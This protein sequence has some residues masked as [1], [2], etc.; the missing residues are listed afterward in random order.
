MTQLVLEL[1]LSSSKLLGWLRI[2]RPHLLHLRPSEYEKP[3]TEK[4]LHFA[5]DLGLHHVAQGLLDLGWDPNSRDEHGETPLHHAAESG[6]KEV[7][8][9][10][11][12]GGAVVNATSQYERTPLHWAAWFEHEDIVDVLLEWGANIDAENEDGET[13]LH[14]AARY[15]PGMLKH[16]LDK[17]ANPKVRSFVGQTPLDWA[18][19]ASERE[20][21][22]AL[23]E[24]EARAAEAQ[25]LGSC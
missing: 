10:L 21:F 24:A 3:S 7:L 14:Y 2:S 12:K 20:S 5:S 22:D 6:Q 8:V 18:A 25:C 23:L 11:L 15:T 17:G 4:A 13:A 9:V 19:I 1:F 16:L